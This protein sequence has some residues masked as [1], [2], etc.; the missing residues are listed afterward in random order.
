MGTSEQ[1]PALTPQR[2]SLPAILGNTLRVILI[3][4]IVVATWYAFRSISG[5]FFE[6]QNYSRPVKT[7]P[8]IAA[9]IDPL[10]AVLPLA[11]QWSFADLDWDVQS[12]VIP[13]GDVDAQLEKLAATAADASGEADTD[14]GADLVEFAELLQL[15][16]TQNG[17]NKVYRLDR[18]N[19][20]GQL[21]VRG[22]AG[23]TKAVALA[24]AYPQNQ[25]EWLLL[26]MKPQSASANSNAQRTTLLPLPPNARFRGGRFANDGQPLLELVSLETTADELISAW[27]AAG[28][29]V[30]HSGMG[31][32]D[33]SS[34]LCARGQSVIYAWSA[35]GRD[36]L[37]NLLLVRAEGE[38]A[39]TP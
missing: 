13:Q 32:P 33:D 21:I 25:S 30:R 24:A 19:L 29:E 37:Q 39:S 3:V 8:P 20:K 34:Y 31:E 36:S 5:L 1:T 14:I 17:D 23:K 6:W 7:K 4:A 27:R 35:D 18:P 11:G 26:E 22:V 38:R 15:Q 10:A 2:R 12:R 16:P 28:W 9:E